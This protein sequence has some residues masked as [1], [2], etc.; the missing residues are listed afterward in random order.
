MGCLLSK[1]T[2]G[3]KPEKSKVNEQ[4]KE[5]AQLK[6]TRDKVNRYLK[7]LESNIDSCQSVVKQC[8]K[9]KEKEKALLGLRKK[10]YI[11]QNLENGRK[12]LLNLEQLINDV[13]SAQM[14]QNIVQAMKQG[15]EFLKQL[16]EQLT[17]EDAEKLMEE[18]AEGIEY[19]QEIGRI[20]AQ[21]GIENEDVL[22]EFEQL[23][24][25]EIPEVPNKPL[26]VNEPVP[27]VAKKPK[28]QVIE[29]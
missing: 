4:D 3:S 20:L 10:K 13:E 28:K 16:N 15:N 5:I 22:E 6:V 21:Q 17:I 25:Q 1:S 29:A 19:Q 2:G 9:N 23:D 27:E 14:N 7:K 8:V 11:E 18:T 24:A 12:Q 26:P